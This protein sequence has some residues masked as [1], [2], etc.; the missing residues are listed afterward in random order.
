MKNWTK[1]AKAF[2]VGDIPE[3]VFALGLGAIIAAIILLVIANLETSSSV[4]A[5]PLGGTLYANGLCSNYN[6]VIGA[7]NVPTGATYNALANGVSGVGNIL[8]Q[9]PLIGTVA[10]LTI[11]LGFVIYAFYR[12]NQGEGL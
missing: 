5:C 10:G 3:L 6:S 2:S 7:G 9:Y 1:K 11:L 8:A 4:A 12:R